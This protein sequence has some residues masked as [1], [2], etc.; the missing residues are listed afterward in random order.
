M[1][2]PNHI[3]ICGE[4]GRCE[5]CFQVLTNV[6]MFPSGELQSPVVP[7]VPDI[8]DEE[9]NARWAALVELDARWVAF[10][11]QDATSTGGLR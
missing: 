7:Q 6:L 10:V 11:S 2:R 5:H 1:L 4:G 8:T 9:L 3:C